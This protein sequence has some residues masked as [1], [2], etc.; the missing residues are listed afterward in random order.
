[1]NDA[2][3]LPLLGCAKYGLKGGVISMS[4]LGRADSALW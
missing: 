4:A 3:I 2:I 1:M